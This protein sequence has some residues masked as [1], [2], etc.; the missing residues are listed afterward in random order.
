MDGVNNGKSKNIFYESLCT[1]EIEN[2]NEACMNA[3]EGRKRDVSFRSKITRFFREVCFCG[4]TFRMDKS[5]NESVFSV[6]AY[7]EKNARNIKG[8]FINSE[9]EEDAL[10][11]VKLLEMDENI[12]YAEI[13]PSSVA[14][15]FRMYAEEKLDT[16]IPPAVMRRIIKAYEDEDVEMKNKIMPRVPFVLTDSHRLFLKS[17][18][19]VFM[20]IEAGKKENEVDINGVYDVFAPIVMRRPGNMLNTDSS[21]LRSAFLDLMNMDF[22]EFPTDF[23]SY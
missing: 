20:E 11:C 18:K 16:V 23:Y 10:D 3:I 17:L 19:S 14:M 22:D 6:M 12:N 5:I 1:T 2:L 8:I 13:H 15:G 7:L 4:D 9:S 21:L